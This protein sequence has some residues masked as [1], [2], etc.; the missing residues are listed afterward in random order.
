[1][2]WKSALASPGLSPLRVPEL[3]GAQYGSPPAAPRRELKTMPAGKRRP[4]PPSLAYA[5]NRKHSRNHSR[6]NLNPRFLVAALPIG[7]ALGLAVMA[8]ERRQQQ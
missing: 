1:M 6:T 8:Y 4:P 7:A 5:G 3:A 2:L